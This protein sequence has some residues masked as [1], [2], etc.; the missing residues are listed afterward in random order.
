M[1]LQIKTWDI[2]IIVITRCYSGDRR[3]YFNVIVGLIIHVVT[4]CVLL[5]AVRSYKQCKNGGQYVEVDSFVY[6]CL[7]PP[8]YSTCQFTGLQQS[9]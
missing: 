7:C 8:Q 2:V 5:G 6:T 3:S 4:V 9:N 1:F